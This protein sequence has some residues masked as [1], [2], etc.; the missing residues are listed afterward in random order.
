MPLDGEVPT[1]VAAVEAADIR[2]GEAVVVRGLRPLGPLR[3]C[4]PRCVA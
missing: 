2:I 3:R 1:T 4:V